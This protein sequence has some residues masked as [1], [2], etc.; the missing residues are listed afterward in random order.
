MPADDT[1]IAVTDE[2]RDWPSRTNDIEEQARRA[3]LADEPVE[4]RLELLELEV[5]RRGLV[6]SEMSDQMSALT[7]IVGRLETMASV[8]VAAAAAQLER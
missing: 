1:V 8:V 7:E 4:R 5:C 3:V 2:V 6:I